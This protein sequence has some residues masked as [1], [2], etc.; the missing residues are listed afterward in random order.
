MC[1]Q[2]GG[3]PVKLVSVYLL[4]LRS[5]VNAD[6]SECINGENPV[7]LAGDLITKHKTGIKVLT[8]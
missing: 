2:I 8:L 7:L 1:V 6:R 3:R 4:P 5:F